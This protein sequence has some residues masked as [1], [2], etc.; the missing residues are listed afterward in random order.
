MAGGP[1]R[2]C[3]P[4]RLVTRRSI[5]P[6][7]DSFTRADGAP[8][9]SLH[10]RDYWGVV[11]RRK[12]L[13]ISIFTLIV[14]AGLARVIFK[15]PVYEATAQVLIERELPSVLDFE[16]NPRA[17]EVWDDFYQTQYRLLQSRLLA[18]KVVE[19]LHLLQD[20][21]FGGPRS[22]S[23]VQAAEASAPGTSAD[24]EFTIDT[25]ADQLK[26]QPIKA[27][28]LVTIAFRS[29]RPELAA[30][31]ANTLG[32]VYIQ[33]TL[34]F[35]YRVSAE[36]G[37]WLANEGD[38]QARKVEAAEAALQKFKEKEGL[39]SIEE[40]R[41][42]LEQ[43]LKDIGSSL[44]AA[45]TKRLEKESV[46]R[47]MQSVSNPE[48]V[49]EALQ[50]PLIQGLKT[51]LAELERQGAQLSAKGYLDEHPEMVRL[52]QQVDGTKQKIAFEARRIIRAA[53][54][55]YQAAASQEGRVADAVEQAKNESLDLAK[56]GLKYDALKR[57]LAASQ[58]LS[59]N[60]LAR[61]KQTDVTRD[62]QASNI[63][64]IDTA[65]VPQG[66]VSPRPVRDMAVAVVLGLGF[67][68]GAAFFRDYLDT[69]A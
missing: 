13:I 8:H 17:N 10:L 21:E 34:E 42:L 24:M 56:R 43:K 14:G 59:D 37:A 48:D 55:D 25:F 53:E 33:Q 6:M 45:K 16:K 2:V 5:S 18:R 67:A 31:V 61:Q 7:S 23:E 20:P 50:S 22:P 30:Q 66:P 1:A 32:E 47:Q 40:R 11:W 27:S 52:R 46:Y 4:L 12:L 68:L 15:R 38:E 29:F 28:Q 9:E 54:I 58:Q 57:D 19:K 49:S 65:V 36:A 60:I 35:R 44:N 39:V 51:Q 26:I 41:T 63:H 62:V 69:S 3:T 64:I